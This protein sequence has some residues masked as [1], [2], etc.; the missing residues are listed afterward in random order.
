[1][2]LQMKKVVEDSPV[3]STE[4][5][6]LLSVAYKNVIGQKRAAWRIL[7][8][9]KNKE[10]EKAEKGDEAGKKK[11]CEEYIRKVEEELKLTCKDVLDV[12]EEGLI[13]KVPEDESTANIEA[14]VFYQKM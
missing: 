13:S 1:M 8:S 9:I 3:L 4:E 14:K 6:N 10:E 12:L 11:I 2:V 5:R 7:S